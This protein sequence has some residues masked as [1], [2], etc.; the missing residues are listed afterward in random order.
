MSVRWSVVVSSTDTESE[1]PLAIAMRSPDAVTA[2]CD[3]ARPAGTWLAFDV[4]TS[5]TVTVPDLDDPVTG[6]ART[7][8]PEEGAEG[9]LPSGRRP[10]R[11]VT[12]TRS[13][14]MATPNGARPV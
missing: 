8:V 4:F 5:I 14:A 9:S 7:I 12:N 2:I 10:A 1:C 6:S 11:F 13:R 3:G